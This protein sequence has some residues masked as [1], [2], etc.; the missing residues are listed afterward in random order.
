TRLPR[1]RRGLGGS[2]EGTTVRIVRTVQL[3]DRWCPRFGVSKTRG[4]SPRGLCIS[5]ID[6]ST[7]FARRTVTIPRDRNALLFQ[8]WSE[9]LYTT[10][11]SGW[12]RPSA[13]WPVGALGKQRGQKL[14][15]SALPL[16]AGA[17]QVNER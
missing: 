5:Q 4:C 6:Q 16:Y 17:N 1:F 14:G 12:L 9:P 15:C 8:G 2:R 10:F 13:R 7:A 11:Q 3:E